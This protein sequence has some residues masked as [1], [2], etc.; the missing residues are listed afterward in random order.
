MYKNKE[1]GF[2][3][4]EV[5][6]AL[7]V[8]TILISTVVGLVDWGMTEINKRSA[9]SH[10][11]LVATAVNRYA[12]RNYETLLAQSTENSSSSVVDIDTLKSEQ[13][14]PDGFG[15]E[16]VWGQGYSIDFRKPREG[17]LQGIILTTGG[18]N[19][20][21]DFQMVTIPS[22]ASLVKGTA[23]FIPTGDITGQSENMLQGVSGAWSLDLTTSHITN[24]GAGHL[25]YLVTID[26]SSFGQEFLYRVEIPGAPSLNSMATD[27]DMTDH[28]IY[29]VNELQFSERDM[30]DNG[31]Y[32]G[33]DL[34]INME[35]F[36]DE[37]ADEGRT[38]MS[39]EHGLYLCR[40]QQITLLSDSRNS[41][42]MQGMTI[43]NADETVD[44]PI[45]PP[46]TGTRPMIFV[47]PAVMGT[48]AN[49]LPMASIQ[50][51][52][53]DAF[54]DPISGTPDI[55]TWQ[56][57]MRVLDSSNAW[58]QVVGEEFGK[59]AVITSCGIDTTAP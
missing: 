51:W 13:Y 42:F 16:N 18:N 41:H 12:E 8:F 2:V 56:V 1:A 17:E 4:I 53:L 57:K 5:I 35:T 33:A 11:E 38:F 14:L 21:Q 19:D 44:K 46:H 34:E 58:T 50:T 52:A 7:T 9:A 32:T 37:E 26:A 31:T 55:T 25:G 30:R 40:N 20:K 54:V 39:E 3:S 29:G 24:S 47:V 28:A 49:P 43:V 15:S 45:C 10:L 23:G 22:T 48:N 6:G 27:L 59:I 36:C